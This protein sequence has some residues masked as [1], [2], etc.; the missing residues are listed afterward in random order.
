V[1]RDIY[2]TR[3]SGEV[4]REIPGLLPEVYEVHPAPRVRLVES[5]IRTEKTAQPPVSVTQPSA[6]AAAVAIHDTGTSPL[7]PYLS[8]ALLGTH[9]SVPGEPEADD[10]HGHGT[11]MSGVAIYPEYLTQIT[12]GRLVAENFLVGVRLIPTPQDGPSSDDPELWAERTLDAIAVAEAIADNR[13]VIHNLSVGAENEYGVRTSWSIGVDQAAWNDGRGRLVVVAAGNLLPEN[14]ATAAQDY[15]GANLGTPM[16]QPAQAWNA[17]TVGGYTDFTG[18]AAEG[19]GAYPDALAP[20]G[21][22]SPYAATDI[23][24]SRPIK[25]DVVEEAGNTAPGGGFPN[26]GS[27]HLSIWT[28]SHR[29]NIG[30]LSTQT[31]ATSPAAAATSA[32]LAIITREQPELGPA[33]VRALYVNTAQWTPAMDQ[34]F[35]DKRDKL[36]AVGYGLPDGRKAA[37]GADSNRPVFL[38]EGELSPG[39]AELGGRIARPIQF[40]KI[41]IPEDLIT[42]VGELP[43][44]LAV[45]LSYFVEPTESGAGR[46]YAGG[47]LRWEM[48]GPAETEEGLRRRVNALARD[49]AAESSSSSG[50]SWAVGVAARSRGSLQHDY[51]NIT[52]GQLAGDR[53]VAIYPVVG[54]WEQRQS[55]RERSIPFALVVSADFGDADVDL[56]NAIVTSV[57]ATVIT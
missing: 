43:V 5:I 55:T 29:H 25:P 44:R 35:P 26:S 34:Q 51:T 9:S 49:P 12:A 36:R 8:P 23:G 37:R 11:E 32:S 15:P 16:C 2:L 27:E 47:R 57:P 28:T 41:R 46:N 6:D 22:L 52:A 19:S 45:T 4:L 14:L 13:P 31:W 21:G 56:Y 20:K 3:L 7:H 42:S 24:G 18:A 50:Y 33:A 39:K 53:L 1:E 10:K 40:V 17:I 54:W 38:Y 30:R 48:Q